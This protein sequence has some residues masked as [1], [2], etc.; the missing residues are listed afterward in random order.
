MTCLVPGCKSNYHSQGDSYVPTFSFPTDVETREK[1]FRAIPRPKGDYEENKRFLVCIHH[2]REEDIERNIEYYNGV[3]MIKMPRK[4]VVLK[5]F[6]V[7]SIFPNC[8]TYFTDAVAKTQ[9]L[10][11]DD[12][13]EKRMQDVYKKSRTEFQE[14]EAKFR[15]SSLSCIISKLHMIEL[16]NDWLFHRPDSSNIL[17]LK[18]QFCDEVSTIERYIIVD[19]SLFCKSFYKEK[20]KIQLSSSSI[21]DI[22]L[23]ENIIHEVDLFEI[24]PST[25]TNTSATSLIQHVENSIH[26]LGQAIDTLEHTD[27]K[28]Y[29][30]IAEASLRMRLTFL[31][32]QL[33]YLI[34]DKHARRYNIITLVFCLKIHGISPACYRLIQGSNCLTFPHERN[35]LKVKN[36]IGLESD[37]TKILREVATTFNNLER[38]VILQMDEVHIRGDASYKGGRVIG[39]IDN[40]NDPYTTV[41]SMMVSSLSA[42]FSTIVRL[43]PLGS[44]SSES[45]YPIVRSTICGIEACGLFVEAVCTDNYPLNVRLYKL[46]STSSKLEPKVQHPLQPT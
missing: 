2:F 38:H 9:R 10:S 45:L 21:N 4:K 24:S 23:L 15:I 18:I 32:D 37:Y 5:K 17:F 35:W 28:L 39:S 46:F 22:R 25:N 36:S 40:P 41:F 27:S 16:P 11:L 42:K 44:S 43:I 13:E 3:E 8:P 1:W 33:K 19:E 6:A 12:K 31:L 29:F 30:E 20:N 34:I 26:S 7:P 14:T